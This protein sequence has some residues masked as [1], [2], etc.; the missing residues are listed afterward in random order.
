MPEEDF[1]LSGEPPIAEI[2]ADDQ[3][4]EVPLE[5]AVAMPPEIDTGMIL[6]SLEAALA[7]LERSAQEV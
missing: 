3:P 1:D 6:N 7:G 5:S 2:E 4:Q